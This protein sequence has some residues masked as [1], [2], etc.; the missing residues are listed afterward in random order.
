M[1]PMQDEVISTPLTVTT[2]NGQSIVSGLYWQPLSKPRPYMQEARQI[3]MRE[4]MDILAIRHRSI[5]Q[6]GFVSKNAVVTKGMYSLAA[7]LAAALAESWLGVIA[8]GLERYALVRVKDGAILPGCD[9]VADQ[10]EI[11]EQLQIFQP[12]YTDENDKFFPPPEFGF[13]NNQLYLDK[14]LLASS[15]KK[16]YRLK[17]LTFGLTSMEWVVVGVLGVLALVGAVVYF[18]WKPA[19][20]MRIREERIRIADEQRHELERLNVKAQQ[21]QSLQPLEHPWPK[22]AE[23]DGIWRVCFAQVTQLPLAFDGWLFQ[24]ARCSFDQ[25]D[26][27]YSRTG[28]ATV[29]DYIIAAAPRIPAAEP[30]FFEEGQAAAVHVPLDMGLGADED[31]EQLKPLLNR[32]SSQFQRLGSKPVINENATEEQRQ[33]MPREDPNDP[34]APK[35]PEPFW[36]TFSFS[37]ESPPAPNETLSGLARPGLRLTENSVNLNFQSAQLTWKVDGEIYARK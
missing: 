23:V 27:T 33:M 4:K 10:V 17:Q 15:H 20:E 30:A 18:Q 11:Q 31:L 7:A 26:V 3:G 14:V 5:I 28:N 25:V 12:F 37:Y 9:I 29:G 8:L 2:V 32:F 13:S 16:Q 24:C 36:R 22:M 34:N 6:A 19:E 21:D 1:G 35:K